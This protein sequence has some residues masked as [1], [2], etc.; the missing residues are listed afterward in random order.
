MTLSFYEAGDANNS[1]VMLLHGGGTL[2]RFWE[3][4]LEAMSKRYHIIAPDLRY[5]DWTRFTIPQLAEDVAALIRTQREPAHLVGL[6]LGGAVALQVAITAPELVCSVTVSGTQHRAGKGYG[7]TLLGW[8]AKGMFRFAPERLLF[9]MLLRAGL[10]LYPHLSEEAR[11]EMV[12][13][14]KAGFIAAI[15][16]LTA[17]D[18][19][20]GLR[21]IRIPTLVMVGALDQPGLRQAA[22]EIAALVPRAQLKMFPR[23][24][25]AWNL[26]NPTLFNRTVMDFID[27]SDYD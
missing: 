6:S 15:D 16:A 9:R 21:K 23:V 17:I 2:H 4:Q 18:L 24:G 19:R 3:P 5:D 27:S 8:L 20:A 10:M 26:Q 14:G 11:A 12:R 7:G 22:Q 13:V 25:H 1:L